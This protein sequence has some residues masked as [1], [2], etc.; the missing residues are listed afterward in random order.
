MKKYVFILLSPT[1]ALLL[2]LNKAEAQTSKNK[3]ANHSS[4]SLLNGAWQTT[5]QGTDGNAPVR[6]YCV[7]HDGFFTVIGKDST[8][9]WNETDAGTYDISGNLYKIKILYDSHPE[10]IGVTHWMEFK[11]EKD[12]LYLNFFKKLIN[13]KG[14]DVTGQMQRFEEKYVRA[15]KASL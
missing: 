6:G 15:K 1:L 5:G 7:M 9:A 2:S 13:P 4:I 10:R 11:L 3:S 12:T 14:E 8:G